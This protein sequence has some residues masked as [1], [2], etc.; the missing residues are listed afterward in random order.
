MNAGR[1]MICRFGVALDRGDVLR[2]DQVVALDLARLQRLE[3]CRVVGDRADD[4]LVELC[5]VAPVVLVPHQRDPVVA[6]PRVELERTGADRVLGAERAGR[7]EDALRVEA[8]LVRVAVLQRLR[9]GDRE[10]LLR[11]RRDERRR[12]LRQRQHR[13]RRVGRLAALVEAL[14]RSAAVRGDGGEATEDDLPVVAGSRVRERA[15][16]VVPAVEV[17]ADRLGVERLA[18]VERDPFAD[19]ERPHRAV[20]VGGPLGRET[21]LGLGRAGLERDQR[22]ED[23]SDHAERLA[24]RDERAVEQDRVGGAGEDERPAFRTSSGFGRRTVA[25]VLRRR[26]L[27]SPPRRRAWPPRAAS[28]ACAT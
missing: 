2:L 21:G 6:D 8:A 3:A 22:L 10:R 23:L 7:R 13:G 26:R 11:E 27:R 19:L 28:K 17:E 15:L 12:R 4:Q 9:A 18:V 20:I 1:S 25:A 16:E 24:V 5:L 14:F